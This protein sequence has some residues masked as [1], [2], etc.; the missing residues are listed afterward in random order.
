MATAYA[1]A[2]MAAIVTTL[3]YLPVG[4]LVAILAFGAFD[5]PLHSLLTFGGQIHIVAGLALWWGIAATARRKNQSNQRSPSRLRC[6]AAGK[7]KGGAIRV[8]SA[9]GVRWPPRPTL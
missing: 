9:F 7:G 3:A 1:V 2:L 8:E 4:A 5:I 6:P